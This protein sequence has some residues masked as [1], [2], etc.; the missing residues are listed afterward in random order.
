MFGF[1]YTFT[2]KQLLHSK[3]WRKKGYNNCDMLMSQVKNVPIPSD[4]P[5]KPVGKQPSLKQQGTRYVTQAPTQT[6]TRK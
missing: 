6:Q 5:P 1:L 2:N 3:F 4:E